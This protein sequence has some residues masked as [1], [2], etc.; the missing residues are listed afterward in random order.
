MRVVTILRALLTVGLLASVTACGA[1]AAPDRSVSGTAGTATPGRPSAHP[2]PI[3]A[4]MP[5]VIGGNAGR[6]SEQMGSKLDMV[7]KDAS[8]QGRS[9]DDPAGWKICG[10]RPGPNQQI[11]DFPVVFEVVPLAE[12]CRGT[13]SK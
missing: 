4:V 2:Q 7:F 11:T 3:S 13:T 10:S 9:V 6:A 5:D 1:S 8:G 12:S